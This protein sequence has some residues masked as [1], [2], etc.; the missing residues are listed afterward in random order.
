MCD[1]YS[2]RY[3]ETKQGSEGV[4]MK[5]LQSKLT[6]VDLA[7]SERTKK[8]HA[9][10]QTLKEAM[11]INKSLSF[12]EQTVNALSK[13]AKF[14]KSSD[15]AGAGGA[16]G[17]GFVP[18]RQSKLTS[19]LKDALGGNCKT[20]MVGTI[21]PEDRH[22]EETISTLRFALRVRMLTTN[23]VVNERRDPEF[24]VKKYVPP[25]TLP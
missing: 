2:V 7:G 16:P 1:S 3:L 12:L 22:L 9:S 11:F 19:V 6:C 25:S 8:T 20:V 4:G 14:P 13:N 15:A 5:G 24:L 23:A 10:G 21:W 18:F 17:G